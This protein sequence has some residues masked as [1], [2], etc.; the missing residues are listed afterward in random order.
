[1]FREDFQMML[2]IYNYRRA[3]GVSWSG[4]GENRFEPSFGWSLASP[5]G[6]ASPGAAR[7]V[8][9]DPIHFSLIQTIMSAI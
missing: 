2:N 9:F 5:S 8:L 1:M 3:D 7:N 6:D 4:K